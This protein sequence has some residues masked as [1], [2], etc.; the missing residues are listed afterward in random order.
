LILKWTK[1]SN[2]C[3]W[4]TLQ[5]KKIAAVVSTVLREGMLWD[6]YSNLNPK[7]HIFIL[8]NQKHFNKSCPC[9]PC[10]SCGYPKNIIFVRP[11]AAFPRFSIRIRMRISMRIRKI[12]MRTPYSTFQYPSSVS[13]CFYLTLNSANI[14]SLSFTWKFNTFYPKCGDS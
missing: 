13:A 8:T 7:W 3:F 4:L 11:K 12:L 14:K 10:F 2:V 6:L 9:L 5:T 1:I